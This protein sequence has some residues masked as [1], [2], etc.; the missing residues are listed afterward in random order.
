MLVGP[1]TGSPSIKQGP[2]QVLSKATLVRGTMTH[3]NWPGLSPI[4]YLLS[5][6]THPPPK[7][8]PIRLVGFSDLGD[9]HWPDHWGASLLPTLHKRGRP[10]CPGAPQERGLGAGYVRFLRQSR[11]IF[12]FERG[13]PPPAHPTEAPHPL[14]QLVPPRRVED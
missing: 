5:F 10:W 12:S 3:S 14:R 2:F 7:K 13:E 6:S 4:S 11:R 8:K 1:P 9:S